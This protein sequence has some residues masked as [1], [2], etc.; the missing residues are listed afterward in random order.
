[1]GKT[2]AGIE[3]QYLKIIGIHEFANALVGFSGVLIRT[4]NLL[5]SIVQ[6]K[7]GEPR[8]QGTVKSHLLLIINHR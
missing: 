3:L 2:V 1:M 6:R 7:G 5:V 8:N 4:K